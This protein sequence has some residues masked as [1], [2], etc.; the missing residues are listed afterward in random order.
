MEKINR[1]AIVGGT[2][3]NEFSGIYLLRKWQAS[4]ALIERASFA[5]ETVFANRKL[6]KPINATSTVT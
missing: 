6:L 2:H 1:V 4:P 3:G 5:T